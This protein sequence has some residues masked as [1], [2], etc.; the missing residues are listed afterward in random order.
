MSRKHTGLV[1]LLVT[2]LLSSATLLV[3]TQ[4]SSTQGVVLVWGPTP[5]MEGEAVGPGDLTIMNEYY[6]VAFAL[7][8]DPPFGIPRGHIVDLAPAG[9]KQ[10]D[11]LA[12]FSFP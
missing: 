4:N 3:N 12:Q 8:T 10:A 2:L 5:I 7:T 1:V 9:E 6:A 11:V